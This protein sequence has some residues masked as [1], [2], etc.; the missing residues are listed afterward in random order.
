MKY[1][2]WRN[3]DS[4]REGES[5]EAMLNTKRMYKT[6]VKM[7]FKKRRNGERSMHLDKLIVSL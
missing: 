7:I 4:F 6:E 2:E 5:H 3:S 1:E